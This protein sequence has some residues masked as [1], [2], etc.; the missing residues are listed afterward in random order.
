MVPRV[1][2]GS[3]GDSPWPCGKGEGKDQ[4]R[5]GDRRARGGQRQLDRLVVA[6]ALPADGTVETVAT[7]NGW[8]GCL[9][10]G[11]LIFVTLPI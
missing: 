3:D 1:S 4:P 11:N 9:L 8:Y 2:P 5:S 10:T 7:V 6:E